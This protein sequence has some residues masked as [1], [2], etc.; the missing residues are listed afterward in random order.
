MT[1]RAWIIQW[2]SKAAAIVVMTSVI[3]VSSA[4]AAMR[5]MSGGTIEGCLFAAAAVYQLPPAVLVI[6]LNVEGGT[7]GEI[8]PDSNGTVDIGPMQVNDIWLPRLARHWHASIP[9]TYLALRDNFCANMDGG[10]WILRQ[11]LNDSHG[12]FWLGVAGY[13][14]G[15]PHYQSSYLRKV[16]SEAMLL[17]ASAAQQNDPGTEYAARN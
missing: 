5:P 16:L 3:H 7:L 10:A 12:D 6:L 9:D 15:N 13:H 14:S 2:I 8:S 11:A 17:E 4:V 1:P